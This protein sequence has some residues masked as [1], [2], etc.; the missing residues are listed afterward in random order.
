MKKLIFTIASVAG[1]TGMALA[2]KMP[3]PVEP[4]IQIANSIEKTKS[5][6][7]N[8]IN[9][10][11]WY[12]NT[13]MAAG[14]NIGSSL[15]SNFTFMY[16]DTNAKLMYQSGDIAH[17][18]WMSY[19]HV[20]DPK[21]DV[22]SQTTNPLIQLSKFV[23]YNFDSIRFPFAYIRHVDSLSDG[24][25][26]MLPVVDTLYVYYFRSTNI[27]K[28]NFTGGAKDKVSLIRYDHANKTAR[29]FFAVDTLLLTKDD[30]TG[31]SNTNG[32]ES[33]F[34]IKVVTLAPPVPV[35]INVNG[36][37]DTNN[38]V[39]V[40]LVFKSA[41]PTITNGGAD[42]IALLMQQDP[43]NFPNQKRGN[44]L[45]FRYLRNS[46]D[47]TSL[48]NPTY[49]NLSQF[50]PNWNGYGQNAN[51]NGVYVAGNAFVSDLFA[52]MD[53]H[54]TTTSD[55][56]GISE[57]NNDEFAMSNVYPNPAKSSE[58]AVLAFNLTKTST[59]NVSIINLV[60]QQV[61]AGFSKSFESGAHAEFLDLSG[62]KAGVYFVNMTVNGSSISKKLTVTE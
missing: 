18:V 53:F 25:G 5:N 42:T 26:G 32:F 1:I 50:M 10:S 56:V 36:G 28:T 20:M 43:A 19:G 12:M 44:C 14:T 45:G 39:G 4:K 7:A 8:K 27:T 17:P 3:L 52:D 60:G 48:S 24:V 54:L 41:V 23:S 22:I 46:N 62:L 61:K 59:V 34:T 11:D 55:N 37:L 29:T 6:N 13:D 15:T 49:Y 38:L 51:W 21:D 31:I 16:A 58:K 47:Q 57:I 30:S 35:S 9:I 33:S 2:Q 40:S